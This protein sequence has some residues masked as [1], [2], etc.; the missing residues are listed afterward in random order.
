MQTVAARNDSPL[1]QRI[2]TCL[3]DRI[4]AGE[5][6]EGH[7]IPPE[8]EL[9]SSYGISVGTLRKAVDS[10]VGE[11]VLVRHQGKGTYVL[12][13]DSGRSLFHFFHI[14]GPNGRKTEPEFE[15]IAFRHDRADRS[16]A[17][18]LGISPHDEVIRICNV[19]RLDGQ[20]RIVDDITI[21]LELFP[22]LTEKRFTS[23]ARTIYHLYQTR[24][25][26]NVLRTDERIRAVAA[27]ERLAGLLRVEDGSPLLEIRRVA[28]TFRDRP[29]ELRVSSVCTQSHDYHHV[30]G[31]EV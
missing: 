8:K 30:L 7:S 24:F 6:P 1:Y 15:T 29:V 10:L 21:P 17:V 13:A 14:E 31:K 22:G 18:A 23:R 19:L 3:V 27:D 2:R 20:P 5:W 28:L 16:T 11:R 9:A 12:G 25:G 26:I 4:S